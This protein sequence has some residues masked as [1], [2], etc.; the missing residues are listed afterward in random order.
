MR[1]NYRRLVRMVGATDGFTLIEMLLVAA[2]VSVVIGMS[3]P[4]TEQFIR[5]MKADSSIGAA[6]NA[7]DIGHDRAISERRNFVLSFIGTNRI[8]LSRQEIDAAGV[9]TSTTV[10]DEFLLENG[11]EFVKFV[12]V[13]DTPD[14][15]GA[16]AVQSFSGTAPVMFTS[17]G[18]LVD[19]NGDVVNGTLFFG[20]PNQP[21]TAR[22]VTIFGVT[23]LTRSWKWRGSQWQD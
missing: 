20:V 19:S 11:Q 10:T 12:G 3:I 21:L 5:T 14:A 13:P 22:A 15:F 1:S 6:M 23:G 9:V 16:T 8:R 7:V 4:I 18:S 2:L 17:D